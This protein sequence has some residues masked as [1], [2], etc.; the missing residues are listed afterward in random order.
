MGPAL[1]LP[2]S[3]PMVASTS[4]RF[5]HPSYGHRFDQPS[6]N[7]GHRLERALSCGMVA[8]PGYL[9]VL[10]LSSVVGSM[11]LM[12]RRRPV[13]I[14]IA[15]LCFVALA[16]ACASAASSS[17][18]LTHRDPKPSPAETQGTATL[19]RAPR[20]YPPG[21]GRDTWISR[22]ERTQLQVN[23]LADKGYAATISETYLI[24]I[25]VPEENREGADIAL[26]DCATEILERYPA[27]TLDPG[28][29]FDYFVLLAECL[30]IEGY[31]ISDPPS[32]DAWIDGY[33]SS[34]SVWVPYSQLPRGLPVD[35]WNRIN[36][37]CPQP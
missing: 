9:Y 36:T 12:T 4:C 33:L 23:C 26:V 29:T 28:E 21:L 17:T 6:N 32:R 18:T 16:Q 3:R 5:A 34:S 8:G 14:W 30:R 11:Q 1:R 2:K 35:E 22:E 27:P 37:V 20:L 10:G 31:D 7:E 24:S 19:E 15:L 13:P 25:D